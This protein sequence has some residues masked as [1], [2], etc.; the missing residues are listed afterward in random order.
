[1]RLTLY[2]EYSIRTLIYLG[3]NQGRRVAIQEIADSYQISA[4]HL[5]KIVCHLS[6]S[7]MVR[8]RRG[9]TGGLELGYP[10]HR[11]RLGDIIR[12]T[13][14]DMEELVSCE[15]ADGKP[16]LLADAYRLRGI[17]ARSLNA[18]MDVLDGVTLHDLVTGSPQRHIQE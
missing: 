12:F 10:A 3:K 7:G 11:I 17:L 9:R 15:P 13:E 14:A 1:M 18:F 5:S 2:T 4:N 6:R 8:S 16:C